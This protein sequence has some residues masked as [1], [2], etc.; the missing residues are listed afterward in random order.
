[1]TDYAHGFGGSNYTQEVKKMNAG[2][3]E[4]PFTARTK[5]DELISKLLEGEMVEINCPKC[6]MNPPSCP[7]CKG[8]GRI[9][10]MATLEEFVEAWEKFQDYKI[11]AMMNKDD[12]GWDAYYHPEDDVP[13]RVV[14]ISFTDA[15]L[16]IREEK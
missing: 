14:G 15:M 6:Y 8:T 1:M 3:T 9:S 2:E 4:L 10:R 7:I 16:K 13:F 12:N 5:Q 11:D